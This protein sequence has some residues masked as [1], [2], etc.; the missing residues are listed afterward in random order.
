M[1]SGGIKDLSGYRYEKAVSNIDVAKMLFASGNYDVALNRAYYAAFDAMRAVNAL[2]GFDSSKHS[3]VIAHF[4][5]EY[6]KT[7]KFPSTT[8]GII[9]NASRL[10]EKSDYEDF[11]EPDKEETSDAI[12]DVEVFLND[13]KA[14]LSSR[15]F[16]SKPH[17]VPLRR[18]R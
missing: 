15:E 11:Y 2:D 8:S 6:V 5:Q 4:N 7:G 16:Y 10:R 3:G 13:V 17:R 1:E 12:M 9:R 14:Y 18:Y